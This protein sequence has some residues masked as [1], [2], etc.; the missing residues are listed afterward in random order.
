MLT[1]K[2]RFYPFVPFGRRTGVLSDQ[3]ST[4]TGI[5]QGSPISPILFLIYNTPLI[6]ACTGLF[7][8]QQVTTYGWVDNTCALVASHSYAANVQA[9]KIM[10]IK[11]DAW[12]RYHA[13]K[14]APNK[15]KVIHFTNLKAPKDPPISFGPQE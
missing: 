13:L 15:F 4:P 1:V 5:L 7:S 3:F 14:F 2:F 11:A 6:S 12:A 10:L 8:Q 9:L